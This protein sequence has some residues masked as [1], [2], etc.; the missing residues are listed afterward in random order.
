MTETYQDLEPG[1]VKN[2]FLYDWFFHYNPYAEV[3]VAI[4]KNQKDGY[5][6]NLNSD[7]FIK[8][9]E[10]STL[11]YIL[12]KTKGDASLIEKLVNGNVE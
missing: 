1:Y 4:P 2:D 6:N 12:H 10:F 9:S 7:Q 5:F 11:L 8:S 3:W